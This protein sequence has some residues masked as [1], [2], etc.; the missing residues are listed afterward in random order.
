VIV[1]SEYRKKT[2]RELTVKKG[3]VLNLISNYNKVC[4]LRLTS[5]TFVF[6]VYRQ[7]HT[8]RLILLRIRP[9][10][11]FVPPLITRTIVSTRSW[12]SPNRRN[13]IARLRIVTKLA[14][15]RP[16]QC[17]MKP[18]TLPP[19]Q[20]LS[21]FSAKSC[22]Q[23]EKLMRRLRHVTPACQPPCHCSLLA[24]CGLLLKVAQVIAACFVRAN[25][26]KP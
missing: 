1:L 16:K 9:E 19:T 6:F 25:A 24:L 12:K 23:N 11:L 4:D 15:L 20:L 7:T 13:V 26:P 8:Y 2:A 10:K 21:M 18:T 14:R 5:Y 3:D 17:S 22:A